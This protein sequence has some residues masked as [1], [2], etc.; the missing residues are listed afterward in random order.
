MLLRVSPASAAEVLTAL[1][2]AL[3]ATCVEED[4]CL[5]PP[6]PG[7]GGT[8]KSRW[9]KSVMP[10]ALPSLPLEFPLS[11]WPKVMCYS[12]VVDLASSP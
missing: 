10:C 9:P 5:P 6:R 8:G 4:I 7:V 11:S 1:V 12:L 3:S 2:K